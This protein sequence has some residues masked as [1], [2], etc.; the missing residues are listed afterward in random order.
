MLS[1]RIRQSSAGILLLLVGVY[2]F[3]VGALLLSTNGVPYV[4]DNNETWSNL[5]HAKNAYD[6]GFTKSKGLADEA[7]EYSGSNPQAHPLVHTHQGNFPRLLPTVLYYLGVR[8]AAAQIAVITFTVGLAGFLFA[9]LLLAR[10]LG[11]SVGLIACL[12]ML[13]DYLMYLQ[14]QV[15]TWRVWQAVFF[16]GPLYFVERISKEKQRIS[17]YI[18]LAVIMLCAAYGE[19]TFA[20]FVWGSAI[21]FA[22]FRCWGRWR[23]VLAIVTVLTISGICAGGILLWQLLSYYGF[24]ALKTDAIYTLTLRNIV[25]DPEKKMEA[26]KFMQEHNILFLWNFSMGSNL[27]V[28]WLAKSIFSGVIAT[29][30]PVF[31]LFVGIACLPAGLYYFEFLLRRFQHCFK[32]SNILRPYDIC[33]ERQKKIWA[34]IL[35]VLLFFLGFVFLSNLLTAPVFGFVFDT[36]VVGFSSL[37][38]NIGVI[39]IT[40]ILWIGSIQLF[41]KLCYPRLAPLVMISLALVLVSAT[42]CSFENPYPLHLFSMWEL[43][44]QKGNLPIIL[45]LAA[46]MYSV[47]LTLASA[48]TREKQAQAGLVSR[49]LPFLLSSVAGYILA[50]M[51]SPGY[52]A[53]GYLD[54]ACPILTYAFYI[55]PAIGIVSIFRGAKSVSNRL[56]CKPSIFVA[57]F[58]RWPLIT[59][60]AA[61]LSIV[62]IWFRLQFFYLILVPPNMAAVTLEAGKPEYRGKGFAVTNYSV[63]VAFSAQGWG[64]I[65][66]FHDQSRSLNPPSP[67]DYDPV[68]FWIS[69]RGKTLKYSRPDYFVHFDQ[70]WALTSIAQRAQQLNAKS[71]YEPKPPL[72]ISEALNLSENQLFYN[73][74]VAQDRSLWNS[75]TILALDKRDFPYIAISETPQAALD[76]FHEPETKIKPAESSKALKSVVV[77]I[78][79]IPDHDLPGNAFLPLEAVLI[80]AG[81]EIDSPSQ[82]VQLLATP[83]M[84]FP[85]DQ[86][87]FSKGKL[88]LTGTIEVP[89]GLALIVKIPEGTPPGT[90]LSMSGKGRQVFS[91]ANTSGGASYELISPKNSKNSPSSSAGDLQHVRDEPNPIKVRIQDRGRVDSS[92]VAFIP[93]Y[94]YQHS[95]STPEGASEWKLWEMKPSGEMVLLQE[96]VKGSPLRFAGDDNARL[97]VSVVPIDAHGVRGMEYFSEI[98][99]TPQKKP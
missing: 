82:V 62:A 83:K 18:C 56:S 25:S 75:W 90:L 15:N 78:E 45:A 12:F 14:W 50:W 70:P 23:L 98:L 11:T 81:G 16:F 38:L 29:W 7:N 86:Y 21:V 41:R 30:T 32:I 97:L 49:S 71:F 64:W 13:T 88:I 37:S 53:S 59:F 63:P 54:R 60:A 96:T 4:M 34:Q 73:R 42:L 1:K 89:E 2:A 3:T 26:V 20:S 6:Y 95:A 5:G 9:Y 74:I 36:S 52:L 72:I 91:Y 51:W 93:D 27:S 84:D 39:V 76:T 66:R 87:S 58:L 22:I 10:I 48:D 47:M 57:D 35:S 8:S 31:L 28:E 65:A 44:F 19:L 79:F 33:D 69:E 24:D 77:R 43:F 61:I 46:L 80:P 92:E 68:N 17:T 94:A 55:F 85:Y 99:R 67:I 40:L